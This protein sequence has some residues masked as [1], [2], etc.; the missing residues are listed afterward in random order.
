ME[1]AATKLL[2]VYNANIIWILL[3][4]ATGLAI[5]Y[6]RLY[7]NSKNNSDS[8]N[9]FIS[10]QVVIK[11]EL[12][13]MLVEI[14]GVIM[15]MLFLKS[16]FEIDVIKLL[17]VSE[18]WKVFLGIYAI[19]HIRSGHRSCKL[20]DQSDFLRKVKR[21]EYSHTTPENIFQDLIDDYQTNYEMAIEKL[22][23]LKA[24]APVSLIPIIA[25][26]VLQG[27]IL[28]INWNWYT[29]IFFGALLFYFFSIWKS[30]RNIR[31]WKNEKSK[32]GAELRNYLSEQN[33]KRRNQRNWAYNER[34]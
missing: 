1:S 10:V 15:L 29:V 33:G 5:Y 30:F 21:G 34:I 12:I 18:L 28:V 13:Q 4:I 32:M 9:K 17:K 26:V 8:E 23:I 16:A 27:N 31:F 2:E 14:I 6:I 24:M 25:G 3:T 19:F 22:N 11:R 7:F 20:L